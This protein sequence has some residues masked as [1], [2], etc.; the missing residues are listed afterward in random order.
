MPFMTIRQAVD[1]WVVMCGD[2]LRKRG[3]V[4]TPLRTI[5]DE[6]QRLRDSRLATSTVDLVE[7]TDDQ[8]TTLTADDVTDAAKHLI[9]VAGLDSVAV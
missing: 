9:R 3:D 1:H 7:L 4:S 2:G 6:A 8:L 5:I